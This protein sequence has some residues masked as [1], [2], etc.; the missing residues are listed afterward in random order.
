MTAFAATAAVRGVQAGFLAKQASRYSARQATVQA[1]DAH[2]A[3]YERNE[4]NSERRDT[5]GGPEC[6][7]FL[8][9]NGLT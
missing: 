4:R 8:G 2:G 7:V 3:G 5:I 1:Q 9:S 6:G